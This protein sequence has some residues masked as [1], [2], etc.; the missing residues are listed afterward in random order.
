MFD[1]VTEA[2]QLRLAAD[3]A[4]FRIDIIAPSSMVKNRKKFLTRR[5]SRTDRG[6]H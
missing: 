3:G 4:V 5:Y 2:F 6:T 1:S